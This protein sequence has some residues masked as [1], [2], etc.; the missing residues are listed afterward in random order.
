LWFVVCC[1]GRLR[2]IELDAAQIV[3]GS[4]SKSVVAPQDKQ[5][6]QKLRDEKY[7]LGGKGK[8][9]GKDKHKHKS[10]DK[11]K[12][13]SVPQGSRV[14]ASSST[15]D[16]QAR[17]Q[18]GT[19]SIEG[20]GSQ[21]RGGKKRQQEKHGKEE[22]EHEQRGRPGDGDSEKDERKRQRVGFGDVKMVEVEGF[23]DGGGGQDG[24]RSGRGAAITHGGEKKGKDRQKLRKVR[25]HIHTYYAHTRALS[26]PPCWRLLTPHS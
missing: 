8:N 4:Y 6:K 12:D 11:I 15:G 18:M 3:N 10:N 16:P 20:G 25:H 14:G 5:D 7:A 13:K 19:G 23:V 17:H 1:L 21:D 24:E 2:F 22:A 26:H 9:K